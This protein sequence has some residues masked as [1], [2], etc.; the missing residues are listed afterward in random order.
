MNNGK[1]PNPLSTPGPANPTVIALALLVVTALAVLLR[2]LFLGQDSFWGDE[3]LSVQ[4]AQ[5]DWEAFRE[6]MQGGVPAMALYYVLLHFWV[7]L[8]DSEFTVRLLSVIFAVVTVPLVFLLGKRLFDARVGLIAALLLAVNA[9]HIEYAQ[10]ARSYA[11]LVFL[12]TLSSWFLIRSIQRPSWGSWAGCTATSVMAVYAHPFAL[13][14]LVAHAGSLVFLPKRSMPW[15]GLLASGVVIGAALSPIWLP[16]VSSLLAS[17]GSGVDSAALSWIPDLTLARV[18]G[19]ALDLTGKGGNLLLLLYL[20]PVL[21]GCVVAVRKWVSARI[22]FE[23]WKYALLLAWL[24]VPIGITFGYSLLVAPALIARYLTVCLP[25]LTLLAAVGIWQTYQALLVRRRLLRIGYLFGSVVLVVVLVGLS[26]RG[27]FAYYTEVKEDW[28]GTADLMLSRWQPGDGIL[29]YLPNMERMLQ[30]YIEKSDLRTPEMRSLV[31]NGY[32]ETAYQGEWLPFLRQEPDRERIMQY[33]PDNANRVWLVMARDRSAQEI[34]MRNELQA[35]LGAKYR[36]VERWHSDRHLIRTA[37][38]SNPIPGVFGGQ[39]QEIWKEIQL[40]RV[41][42]HRLPVTIVGTNGDDIIRGT[43]GDDVIHAFDGNDTVYGL[44]GND[45]I[46]GKDGND[47][48][49]GGEGDDTVNGFDGND[50]VRGGPGDDTLFGSGANDQLFG[51]EGK[52]TLVGGSGKD[53][54]NGGAGDDVLNGG[55]DDDIMNGGEGNDTHN[56]GSGNDFSDG[57]PGVDIC[58]GRGNNKYVN[59]EPRGAADRPADSLPNP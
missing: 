35:A 41:V 50:M 21:I 27:A 34:R 30:H 13:L 24:F 20:I 2:L 6:F 32:P 26:V 36:T 54:L 15:S 25:P 46:C 23:S 16:V 9:F 14:V 7:L 5:L 49:D 57:G 44:G 12:V 53:E 40:S 3:I 39:W 42:C 48:L 11:L 31:P 29:F 37:L 43:E 19:F 22:S 58:R 17:P 59:C 18:H 33:L 47:I 10:E 56:S 51:D 28:R 1:S 52:D 8:G 38:Y 4:R 45:T 55:A